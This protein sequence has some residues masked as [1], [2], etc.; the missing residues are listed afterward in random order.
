MLC[1]TTDG[2][3]TARRRAVLHCTW[4]CDSTAPCC[5]STALHCDSTAPCCSST[6]L[7]CSAGAC[8]FCQ[9]QPRVAGSHARRV[10]RASLAS[11]PASHSRAKKFDESPESRE[12]GLRN[13]HSPPG[14]LAAG[15]SLPYTA[16]LP[17]GRFFL[18]VA[19]FSKSCASSTNLPPMSM[20]GTCAI[21][22]LRSESRCTSAT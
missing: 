3:A 1:C 11:H 22:S 16:S 14:S 6:A 2:T 10:T 4:H 20:A 15:E 8:A 12:W 13:A 21:A 19:G 5:G 9:R 7:H 17:T 18:S